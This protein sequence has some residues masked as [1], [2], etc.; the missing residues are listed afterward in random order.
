MSSIVTVTE[1]FAALKS[2]WDELMR[3]SRCGTIFSTWGWQS[4]WWE[5]LGGGAEPFLLTV[6]EGKELIGIVPLMKHAGSLYFIG[7]TEVCDYLDIVACPGREGEVWGAALDYLLQTDWQQV[8]LHCLRASSA[9][10]AYLP[11]LAR[12]KG[13]KVEQQ[14]VDVCPHLV[15]PP[16]WEEFLASLS[17]KDRHELRR[18]MRRLERSGAVRWYAV[19]EN[20][21]LEA[22]MDDFIQLHRLSRPEKESF[23]DAQMEAFFRRIADYFLPQRLL[24]LYFLEI[25][26]GRVASCI[27]LEQGEEIWLYNS[28][29]DRNHASLSVGL[30]LKV[31]C[32]QAAIAAG[33]KGFDFLRGAEP[34]KYDLGAVDKPLYRLLVWRGE[35]D[36]HLGARTDV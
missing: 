4:I 29:F 36:S 22:D 34:Y 30:L 13:L 12:R 25:G 1:D 24:K 14:T 6:R 20:G 9:T 10:L 11:T 19:Q 17:K 2:E 32:V 26:G 28:G 7:G 16:S 8:N 18:K 3:R 21:R 23:M 5:C 33:K 15:L 27:C 31:F 35:G